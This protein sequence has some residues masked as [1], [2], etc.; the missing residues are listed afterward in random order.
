MII[1]KYHMIIQKNKAIKIRNNKQKL[2][3]IG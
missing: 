1:Q 2:V 3:Y